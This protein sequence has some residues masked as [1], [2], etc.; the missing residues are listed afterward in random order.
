MNIE[1]YK[2]KLESSKEYK[3]FKEEY[4]DS[5]ITSIFIAVDFVSNDNK[6]HIDFYVPSKKQIISFQLED[7]NKQ[8]VLHEVVEG[9]EEP[10]RLGDVFNLSLNESEEILMKKIEEEGIKDK[11]QKILYS[12]QS[13]NGENYWLATVF[14]SGFSI[15][16][17]KIDDSKK[18][19]I[20]FR[21]SSF[22]DMIT[23]GKK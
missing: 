15:I 18:Q 11:V 21:K 16:N 14:L 8:V 5:F 9:E 22:M 17:A 10:L 20:D 19:I 1:F 3:K 2:E 12:I 23:F 6:Q 4:P 13:L 7:N